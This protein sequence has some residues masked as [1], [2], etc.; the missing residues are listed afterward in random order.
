MIADLALQASAVNQ[1]L[2]GGVVRGRLFDVMFDPV[3][4]FVERQGTRARL[5]DGEENPEAER[6]VRRRDDL[7]GRAGDAFARRVQR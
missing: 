3:G 5:L 6:R 1:V 2:F 7:R 4:D